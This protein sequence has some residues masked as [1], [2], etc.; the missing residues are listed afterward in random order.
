M[1]LPDRKE[2]EARLL[3]ERRTG[4]PVPADLAARALADGER[5]LRRRRALRTALWA[6][7]VVG[8]AALV[9]WSLALHPWAAPPPTTTSPAVGW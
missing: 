7:L 2:A 6:G 9:A 8:L 5:L 4:E 1:S 3:L